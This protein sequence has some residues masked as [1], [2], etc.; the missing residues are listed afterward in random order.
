[1]SKPLIS[2]LCPTRNHPTIV[3]IAIECFKDQTYPNRELILVADEDSPYIED[4]IKLTNDNIKLF[5]A[6]KGLPIGA[7]R[8]IS[9][10]HAEGEYIA[11]WDDDNIHHRDRLTL[12]Y[13]SIKKN[14]KQACFLRR[15][16]IND[17]I[18]GDKG[19]SSVGRGTESTIVAL[20]KELPRYDDKARIAEDCHARRYFL[21]H[22]DKGVVIDEPQLYIYNIHNNNT[23]EY[24]HLKSMMD[25]II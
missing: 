14:S 12:Q 19:I 11:Q 21:Q 5:Y 8:N 24:R 22:S 4:L 6:P 7:I 1:M 15:V 20:K 25:T 23:C 10:S 9:V 2:C 3:K 18:K 16:L 13:N 17:I